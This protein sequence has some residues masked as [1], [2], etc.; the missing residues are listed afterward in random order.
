MRPRRVVERDFGR[1]LGQRP[2]DSRAI[3]R[4]PHLH[5]DVERF[6]I[7]VELTCEMSA[8]SAM[9]DPSA[10]RTVQ[11]GMGHSMGPRSFSL[12]RRKPNRMLPA[13][14]GCLNYCPA[15]ARIPRR[16]AA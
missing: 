3:L 10:S 5:A 8:L 12:S 1:V 9:V 7:H 15:S 4:M 6:D 14:H 13:S 11:K 16:A 2:D